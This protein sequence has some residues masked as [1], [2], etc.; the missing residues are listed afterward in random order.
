MTTVMSKPKP[1]NG[2]E[3]ADAL[4]VTRQDVS[5]ALKR[6]MRKCYLHIKRQWPELSPIAVSIFLMKWID[7]VGTIKFD[8]NEIKKFNRLYPPDIR[9]EI[10]ADIESKRGISVYTIMESINDI[11][12]CM[13]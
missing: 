10:D 7:A 9:R 8:L 4:G 13:A 2:Q 12:E 11:F 3:I 6:A 1:M 5:N